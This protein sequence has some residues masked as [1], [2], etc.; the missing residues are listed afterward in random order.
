MSAGK[1]RAQSSVEFMI[2]ISILL[3]LFILYT[4]NSLSLQKDMISIKADQEAKK[5]SDR[6]A[7]EINTAVKSGDGYERSFFIESSFAGISDFDVSVK[8][9]EVK[10]AWSQNFVT[11][12]IVT[13]NTTGNVVKGWNLIENRDGVIYVS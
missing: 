12:Q 8:D 11:S 10:V 7:F 3:I 6:I 9:Y 5:L 2:L 13:K 1:M 4:Q